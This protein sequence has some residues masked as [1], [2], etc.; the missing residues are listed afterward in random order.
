MSIIPDYKSDGEDNLQLA[1]E[2]PIIADTV[3]TFETDNRI[4][5]KNNHLTGLL[6][7]TT[8]D[9]ERFRQEQKAYIQ[10]GT[11]KITSNKKYAKELKQKRKKFDDPSQGNFTGPW[12]FYEGE[13]KHI[14]D[15]STL[16]D[17]QKKILTKLEEKRQKKLVDATEEEKKPIAVNAMSVFHGT[18]ERDYQG[19]SYLVP[20]SELKNVMH[21]CFIPRKWVHT[22]VGHTKG[23]QCI[24]FLPI[25]GHFILSASH[26]EKIKLWDVLNNRKL[27]RTYM[28]HTAAIKDLAFTLDG[29]TFLSAGF[30]KN[31]LLWD[32]EYGK[33]I[34]GFTNHKIPLCCKIHPDPDKQNIFLV[35]TE[36]KK[37]VQYD[38]R[39]GDLTMQYEEHLGAVNTVTFFDNNKKIASTADDKKIFIWEFG[40]PV[41]IKHV[42]EPD[43][44]TIPIAL[45]HPNGKYWVG[46]SMDNKVSI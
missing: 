40:I 2:V 35:G 15:K 39:T 13:E 16:T 43:M 4:I 25:Y 46:Q 11:H 17:D 19:R 20:P 41:V 45:L 31:I 34:R 5:Y 30:D 44:H 23:I 22:Y 42:T 6:T 1:P 8:V 29:K 3:R 12:A 32:T 7:Y 26:D 28:G 27:T 38:A 10:G 36:N 37:I 21:Q 9:E 33:V 14:I 24:R 18:M